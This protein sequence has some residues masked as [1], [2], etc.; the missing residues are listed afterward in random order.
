M[1]SPTALA[2]LDGLY[3]YI[4]QCTMLMIRHVLY[5]QSI[6]ILID[7]AIPMAVNLINR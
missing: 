4:V 5:I 1:G 2:S 6:F 3:M 7:I